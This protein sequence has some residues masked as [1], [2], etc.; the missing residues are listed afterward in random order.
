VVALQ[1]KVPGLII[2]TGLSNKGPS[3]KIRIR[4]YSSLLL[5][6]EP[7]VLIDG[8]PV[9]GP[10]TAADKMLLMDINVV[11]RVEV[12]LRL[13][14]LYGDLGRNGVIAIFTKA[15]ATNSSANLQDLKTVDVHKVYGY[16]TSRE[17][18]SPNYDSPTVDKEKPDYRSTIYWNPQLNTDNVAGT[19]SVSFFAADLPGRYRIIVEGLTETGKPLRAESFIVIQN[20]SGL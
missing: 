1:G 8:I 4:G 16:S 14:S 18:K 13:N 19:C 5:S 15:G 3:Y 20:N 12:T 10:G 11:D 17:F 2:T 9:G 6:T 7:L